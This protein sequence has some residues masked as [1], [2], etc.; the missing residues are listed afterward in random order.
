MVTV[1]RSA[2]IVAAK[3]LLFL[4]SSVAAVAETVAAASK[5]RNTYCKKQENG[6]G[7]KADFVFLLK[8]AVWKIS[9]K[10]DVSACG[11]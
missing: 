4:L 3:I 11:G 1:S 6:V 8:K 9:D 7:W 5:N 2:I 10:Q